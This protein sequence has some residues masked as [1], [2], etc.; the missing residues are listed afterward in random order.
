MVG[1]DL[2]PELLAVG[3]VRDAEL[4][5]LLRNADRLGGEAGEQSQPDSL[6]VAVDLVAVCCLQAA[7]L[8]RL[9]DGGELLARGGARFHRLPQHPVDRIEMRDEAVEL[10]RP[11]LFVQLGQGRED[12]R[13]CEKGP[14]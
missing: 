2:L 3:D 1:A 9:V 13:G 14:E 11:R 12:D 4:E 6:E 5:R 7:Q 8:A 10:D